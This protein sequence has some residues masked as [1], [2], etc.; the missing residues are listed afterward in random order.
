MSAPN[1]DTH[2]VTDMSY[3]FY[4]ASLFDKDIGKWDT[5]RVTTMYAMF[6]HAAAFDKDIGRWDTS[7]VI[8]MLCSIQCNLIG[9]V[10]ANYNI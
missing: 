2:L 9:N 1:R 5:S 10:V 3:M 7:R 8:T 6:Y 4:K